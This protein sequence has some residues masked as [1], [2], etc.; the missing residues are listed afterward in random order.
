MSRFAVASV[1][2]L[3]PDRPQALEES[4]DWMLAAFDSVLDGAM[5]ETLDPV[6][7]PST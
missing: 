2:V 5:L 1:R 6:S 7:I 4:V 3:G